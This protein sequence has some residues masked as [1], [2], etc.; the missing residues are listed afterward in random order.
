MKVPHSAPYLGPEEEEAVVRVLRS[1]RL[2]QG[3]EVS[4]F[5][6]ECAAFVG[7]RHAVAVSSGTAALHLVLQALGLPQRAHVAL[8]SY[9]CAS[10]ITAARLHRA[11]PVLCDIGDDL[12]LDPL[13]VPPHTAAVIVPHLFG[14]PAP[15]PEGLVIED[16][17][18]SMG[19]GTGKASRVA[20][21]S[22]YATKLV[23]TGEGGMVFT[24]DDS[25]AACV[26]DRRDYDNR[27]DFV[28]RHNYK[29][30]DMQ[31]AIGRVQ[32]KRLPD[33]LLRRRDIAERYSR[34][35]DGLPLLL[36]RASGHAF[37]RYVVS[38]GRRGELETH[39]AACGVEAKRPV[40]RPA[41]HY[42]GGVFPHA[43]R[44]HAECLSL[45]IY[46][47][48]VDESVDHV[49]DSVLQFFA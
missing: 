24:D 7:R 48:L 43:E 1:G 18:Q 16:I 27:D 45:P 35:F 33:F 25:L 26:R 19:N 11:E 29:L 44:A 23:T 8:P 20:I 21:T 12:N 31:A 5:E 2:A 38:T 41:H 9:G 46:P 32:V 34:A 4:A 10:L 6:E 30:T 47:K 40:Y 36:P 28:T 39:L 15:I 42:L 3:P 17:A 14:A 13:C 22:F 37:F 49:I